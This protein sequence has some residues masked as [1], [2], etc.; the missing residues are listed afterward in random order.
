MKVT[1]TDLTTYMQT[2]VDLLE[3]P[4]TLLRDPAA[5]Q[6]VTEIKLVIL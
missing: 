6:A 2:M 3:D 5:K 1:T 4:I